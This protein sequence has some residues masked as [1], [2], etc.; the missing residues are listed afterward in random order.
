MGSFTVTLVGE[1]VSEGTLEIKGFYDRVNTGDQLVLISVPPS[2]QPGAGNAEAVQ[3]TAAQ[4][5]PAPNA[6]SS[7]NSLNEKEESA[8]S[9]EDFGIRRIPSFVDLIR[10]IY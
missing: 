5:R 9:A 3:E 4:L 7:G 1:E 10:S 6:D 2:E 8:L